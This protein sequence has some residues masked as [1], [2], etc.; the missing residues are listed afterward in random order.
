VVLGALPQPRT[1]GGS[2]ARL[3]NSVERSNFPN[4]PRI[5]MKRVQPM[6]ASMF[7]PVQILVAPWVID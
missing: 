5:L 4:R 6:F 3:T 1:A 2:R 7:V